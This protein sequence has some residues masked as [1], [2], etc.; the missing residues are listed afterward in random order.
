MKKNIPVEELSN[1]Y[2]HKK[3]SQQKIADKYSCSVTTIHNRL[4]EGGIPFRS[5]SAAQNKYPKFDFNGT[6]VEKAYI[7]G[8]RYGDLNVYQPT[9]ASE[10]IVV[11]SHSTHEVQCTLFRSLFDKYGHITRSQKENRIQ[12]TCYLNNSFSFLLTKFPENIQ[13][14]IRLREDVGW[15]FAA[16]YIDAEGTFGLNQKK[17][18]FK[19]DSYDYKIL[20]AIHNLLIKWGVNSKFYKIANKGDNDYGWV[21]KEDLW[22]ISVNEANSLETLISYLLPY[23]RHEKRK[24]DANMVLQ[25]IRTRRLNGTI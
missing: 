11:R 10:T 5:K 15:A 2:I 7:L 9:G 6:D 13:K 21:W 25:N 22:R 18:R 14:W 16:G 1:L 23:V 19:V 8:F 4:R 12:L 3:W 20:E 24:N 17:G